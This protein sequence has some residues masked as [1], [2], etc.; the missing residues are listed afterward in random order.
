[1][2]SDSIYFAPTDLG[3]V[4]RLGRNK[5]QKLKMV[6]FSEESADSKHQRE[7]GGNTSALSHDVGF[8]VK[9]LPAYHRY[10]FVPM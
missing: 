8:S 9:L 1:M 5:H 2:T 6:E 4:G 10:E 7:L 3:V